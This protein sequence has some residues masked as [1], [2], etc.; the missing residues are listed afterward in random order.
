MKVRDLLIFAFPQTK[1]D[2]EVIKGGL[3]LYRKHVKKHGG[4]RVEDH[5]EAAP[6]DSNNNNSPAKEKQPVVEGKKEESIAGQAWLINVPPG[7]DSDFEFVEGTAPFNPTNLRPET[8]IYLIFHAQQQVPT[9]F[10]IN[11][12]TAMSGPNA[13]L[14]NWENSQKAQAQRVVGFFKKLGI[15]EIFKV[16]LV[17]CNTVSESQG[18]KKAFLESFVIELH[19]EGYHPKIAGW[20]I[21]IEVVTDE[22]SAHY[23]RK[24]VQSKPDKPLTAQRKDH[25]FVYLYVDTG[26]SVSLGKNALNSDGAQKLK[27]GALKDFNKKLNKQS[28]A[29]MGN[30]LQETVTQ[31]TGSNNKPQMD[32][33]L[34]FVQRMRYTNSGWSG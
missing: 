20:D 1:T 17:A 3:A 12:M 14:E 34:Q 4:P 10:G 2:Q 11:M 23:G 7:P 27:E 22:Q 32:V 16:C 19:N 8:G 15:K 28:A 29:V 31:S 33:R 6:S 25:K 13:P 30:T 24:Q 26:V 21:P 5:K 18:Q 9:M